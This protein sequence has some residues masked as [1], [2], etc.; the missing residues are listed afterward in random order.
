MID[1][2]CRPIETILKATVQH[3]T[4]ADL[5]IIDE[6]SHNIRFFLHCANYRADWLQS[7]VAEKTCVQGKRDGHG[8]HI[9]IG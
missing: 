1:A 8:W 3:L 4:F 5:E 9:G 2:S 6:K 7:P